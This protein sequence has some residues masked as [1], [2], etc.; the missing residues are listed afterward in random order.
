MN[1]Q[2]GRINSP[3]E[4]GTVVFSPPFDKTPCVYLICGGQTIAQ[5]SVP[6][7][8]KLQFDWNYCGVNVGDVSYLLWIAFE[9]E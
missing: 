5:F 1:I 9:F 2:T 6:S 7:I 4:T 8:S 3:S